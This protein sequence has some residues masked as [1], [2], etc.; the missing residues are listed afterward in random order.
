MFLRR[1]DVARE[2]L[3]VRLGPPADDPRRVEVHVDPL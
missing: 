2:R 3:Q 1:R